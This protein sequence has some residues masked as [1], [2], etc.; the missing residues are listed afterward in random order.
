LTCDLI[1][2][3]VE[4]VE[5]I[6]RN[7]HDMLYLM[8]NRK[9]LEWVDCSTETCQDGFLYRRVPCRPTSQPNSYT[10]KCQ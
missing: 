7:L 2:V 5:C 10:G 8:T 6:V 9:R 1:I 4:L 3:L